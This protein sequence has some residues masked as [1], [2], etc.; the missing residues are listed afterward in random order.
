MISGP[1]NLEQNENHCVHGNTHL[2]RDC[3][4]DAF[5]KSEWCGIRYRISWTS[6]T[7]K[8]SRPVECE[9]SWSSKNFSCKRIRTISKKST[10]VVF[11]S[12][13]LHQMRQHLFPVKLEHYMCERSQSHHPFLYMSNSNHTNECKVTVRSAYSQI[14][15][16]GKQIMLVAIVAWAG[17]GIE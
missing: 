14:L 1:R 4:I 13:W 6:R 16:S 17:N 9:L 3:K 10:N 5:L 15:C 11:L 8:F 7:I 12:C 2:A